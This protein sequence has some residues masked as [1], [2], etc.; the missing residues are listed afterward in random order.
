MFEIVSPV[1]ILLWS[2][3]KTLS[4]RG[5]GKDKF[6]DLIQ[7]SAIL[8]TAAFSGMS[9]NSALQELCMVSCKYL[10]ELKVSEET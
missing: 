2:D 7:S 9:F 3:F 10:N 8:L 4:R 6:L 5:S 1:F